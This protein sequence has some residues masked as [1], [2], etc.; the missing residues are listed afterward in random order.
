MLAITEGAAPSVDRDL[1]ALGKLIVAGLGPWRDVDGD[2]AADR[3]VVDDSAR[4]PGWVIRRYSRID[5]RGVARRKD[6]DDADDAVPTRA[7]EGVRGH[8]G[9][10]GGAARSIHRRGERRRLVG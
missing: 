10:R 8:D 6:R 9:S 5:G 3:P 7:R 1:D 2:G 4:Q